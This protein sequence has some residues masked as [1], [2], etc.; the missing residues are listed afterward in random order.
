MG[1]P[2]AG[3]RP[4][5][6]IKGK[7]PPLRVGVVGTDVGAIAAVFGKPGTSWNTS[8][9]RVVDYIN[10][11]GGV[12][13]RQISAA[14]FGADSGSDSATNGQKACTAM[15]EDHKVDIVVNVG[16]LGDVLPACVKQRGLAIFDANSWYADASMMR[17]YPNWF[18]P[19][20]IRLDRSVQAILQTALSR[21][22]MKAGSRLGVIV[23]GCPWG[24]RVYD[25]TVVPFAKKHGIAVTQ[26]GIKCIDNIVADL[27]PVQASI[28]SDTLRFSTAGVTHVL[29]LSQ[30]EA[31]VFAQ[32]TG[33]ASQQK[34]F[35]TYLISS[36]A[37]AAQNSADDAIIKVSSDAL[38]HILGVGTLPY[39]DTLETAPANAGQ[40]ANRARCSKADPDRQQAQTNPFALNNFY[41]M[42]DAFFAMKES[43]EAAGLRVAGP[44]VAAG[45]L[46]LLKAGTPSAVLTGG[47][48]SGSMPGRLDGAGF[49]RP[50]AYDASSKRFRY[51]GAAVST[52]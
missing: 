43:V 13:G 23:E 31:F 10:T 18:V 12:G 5:A 28:Q 36:Q 14:Y 16:M 39:L 51:V 7:L 38:Q 26:T 2:T 41:G 15:T 34:F 25:G 21:G 17:E 30:A 49:V 50:F 8:P 27:A 24:A 48:W 52:P 45:W 35:P 33:Q 6:G 46:S 47:V 20:A 4:V 37:Y 40:Q 3:S 1:M 29:V 42:C 22:S 9:K 11:T 44:E 32:F 19:S